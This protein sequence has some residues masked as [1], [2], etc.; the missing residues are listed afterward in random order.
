MSGGTVCTLPP[1]CSNR[2]GQHPQQAPGDSGDPA[3][4]CNF[5]LAGHHCCFSKH[6]ESIIQSSPGLMAGTRKSVGRCWRSQSLSLTRG[7]RAQ[8]FHATM[9]NNNNNN[10]ATFLH[11]TKKQ[12]H[13]STWT[14]HGFSSLSIL[15]QSQPS[16]KLYQWCICK[17]SEIWKSALK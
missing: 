1:N 12:C 6:S 5:C 2:N 8:S 3:S 16:T 9:C 17:K 13:Y 15:I 11:F 4:T 10:T 7:R 14:S